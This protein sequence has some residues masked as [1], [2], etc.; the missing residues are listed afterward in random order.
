MPEPPPSSS[1]APEILYKYVGEALHHLDI[2][3]QLQIR[4]TQPDDLNDPLDCVPGVGPPVD[5]ARFVDDTM[6]RNQQILLASGQ[7]QAQINA[8]RAL[9][10]ADYTRDPASLVARCAVIVRQNLNALGV[11]SL[12]Q[13]NDNMPMWAHYSANHSGF[14]IGLR[15]DGGP[16]TRRPGDMAS[17]GE[18]RPVVYQAARVMTPCDPLD[19]PPEVLFIKASHWSYEE[20]WRV[21]RRLAT[22]D[23]ALSDSSGMARYHLCALDAR[24]VTRVDVGMNATSTTL[25]AVLA[26][27]APGTPL[28][29]VEVYRARLDA[30]GAALAFELIR[31]GI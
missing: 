7:T 19:L 10:I 1:P 14:A 30:G 20:E 9:M 8:G 4:F 22:C 15:S 31:S 25:D 23:R 2:L 6:A 17:E 5:I 29:H 12:A 18:L 16:L 26:A 11:L 28:Q 27:S 13:R 24:T 3:R 21:V